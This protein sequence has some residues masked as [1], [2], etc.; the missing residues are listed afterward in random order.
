M[1]NL[2]FEIQAQ[3]QTN[4]CWSACSVSVAKFF[5]PQSNW[6]QCAL[7]D[8]ELNQVDCCVNGASLDCNKPWY[9]DRSLSR[10]VHLYQFFAGN[11]GFATVDD[12]ITNW[13]C[14][15]GVRIGWNAGGGHF[16]LIS[17]TDSSNNF[18]VVKD[19]WGGA[20]KNMPYNTLRNNY[21][22]SGQWTH[23]YRTE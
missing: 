18:V 19:P 14:P 1:S 6:T 20:T 13:G 15:V 22:G 12:D 9:F 17:G 2:N 8:A 7:A 21:D 11:L 23:T 16:V 4:W 5:N 3:E 10:V